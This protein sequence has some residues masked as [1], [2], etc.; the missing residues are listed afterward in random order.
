[1]NYP[2]LLSQVQAYATNSFHQSAMGEHV[3]HNRQHTESVASFASQIATH[4]KLN[5]RDYFVVVAAAWMHDLGYAIDRMTHEIKGAEATQQFLVGLDVP[6][7]DIDSIRDCILSTKMPQSPHNLPEEIVC[8]ADLF[9]IG[10][11]QFSDN[12][13]LVRKEWEEVKHIKVNKDEWRLK[14]IRF[15]EAHQYHTDY[16]KEILNEANQAANS[17]CCG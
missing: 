16:A 10:T 15:F 12:N 5:E 17:G 7:E 11:K 8:D 14:T 1:M 6:K 2:A 13:K 9:H 4:Y 3:Y